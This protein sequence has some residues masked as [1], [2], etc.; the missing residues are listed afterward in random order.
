MVAAQRNLTSTGLYPY[1]ALSSLAFGI[2][3]YS[4]SDDI[5]VLEII[6]ADSDH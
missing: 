4:I 5:M 6:M 2:P 1:N 3:G